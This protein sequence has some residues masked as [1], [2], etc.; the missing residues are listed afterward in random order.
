MTRV[1]VTGSGVVSPLGNSRE[2]FWASLLAGKSG[3]RRLTRIPDATLE[4][5]PCRIGG[6]VT[7]LDPLSS[8]FADSLSWRKM[9]RAS[10]YAVLACQDAL[11]DAQLSPP[12]LGQAAVIVGAGLNGMETLQDQTERLLARGPSRVSPFT[13]P[14]LMPNAAPSNIAM[15]FGIRGPAWTVSTA[16]ASA[17]TAIV[18]AA[19]AIKN[20]RFERV[21]VG[22]TESSLT[23]LGIA[24][25]CRMGAMC[26]TRNSRPTAAMRPFDA[27]RD[28]MVMSE[29][30]AMLVLESE[31][32]AAARGIKHKAELLGWGSTSD[33]H[34]SVAPHPEGLGLATAIQRA[35]DQAGLDP[36]EIASQLWVNAHG[37]STPINDWTETLALKLT[38]GRDAKSLQ[39]S[40]T[41]SMT[42]HTIGACAALESVAGILAL[43]DGMIPPTINLHSP[44]ADCDLD[45]VPNVS[46][47]SE[48]RFVLNNICGFG[49]HN[50]ALVFGR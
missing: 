25:F 28:G 30:S 20:G 14:R 26:Q 4:L 9:D 13:I 12:D 18:E 34:H 6:E 31:D 50:V 10:R 17:G 29:G 41:K 33:C 35:I 21:I 37:T 44:D 15:A 27:T 45:Y 5:L 39:I 48:I 43:R 7:G 38:F 16:C 40:S 2:E 8:D 22:G 36:S 46:R 19:E 1:F 23:P 3:I 24:S 32:S 47:K 11:Q 49:G 42:G